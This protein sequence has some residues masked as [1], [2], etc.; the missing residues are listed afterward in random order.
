[1]EVQA[2]YNFLINC[3]S[4]VALTGPYAGI[5]PTLLAPV[6][7]HGA[8]L[9]G[10]KVRDCKV[11][12]DNEDYYS[13]ELTGPI[14]PHTIH[15]LCRLLPEDHSITAT[16]A[17]V[18]TVAS[19]SKVTLPTNLN[20]SKEISNEQASGGPVFLQ[21]NLSDCGLKPAILKQFCSGEAKH[22]TNMECLKYTSETKTYSW[23]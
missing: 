23:T 9:N 3:K 8:T 18:P 21:E 7:F 20:N 4:A 5:P 12:V 1:M 15:N 22:V 6:A 17:N 10:L 14:L 13:L 11:H 19:F 2:F 16:F